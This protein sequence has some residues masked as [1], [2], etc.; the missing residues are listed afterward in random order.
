MKPQKTIWGILAPLFFIAPEIVAYFYALD[1]VH[2]AQ[3][4]LAMHPETIERYNYEIL[5]KFLKMV[6]LVGSILALEWFYWFVVFQNKLSFFRYKNSITYFYFYK[7]NISVFKI[8]FSNLNTKDYREKNIN[9]TCSS[10]H[11]SIKT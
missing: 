2:Y 9:F 5:I 3:N 10:T 7:D 11:G 8:N 1:I 6:V 4:G